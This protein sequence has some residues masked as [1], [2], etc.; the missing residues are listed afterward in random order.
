MALVEKLE[1][2]APEF[3]RLRAG[4]LAALALGIADDSRTFARKFEIAHALVLRELAEL[5][6][7]DDWLKVIR[8]DP[9]T[10][11]TWY[12]AGAE[13]IRSI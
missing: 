4:I 10:Q 3:S 5:G 6:G 13:L 9:R 2:S 11:R 1:K 8:R 12:E 7:R